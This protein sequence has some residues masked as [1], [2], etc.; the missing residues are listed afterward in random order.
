[1]VTFGSLEAAVKLQDRHQG[2][3]SM[4]HFG[5]EVKRVSSVLEIKLMKK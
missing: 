4:V 5:E 3:P 1:M 2:W